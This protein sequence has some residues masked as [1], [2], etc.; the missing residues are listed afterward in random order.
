MATEKLQA[1]EAENARL[2]SLLKA[3]DRALEDENLRLRAELR[4]EN[5]RLREAKMA[6]K[7][8]L[9][10]EMV[11]GLSA[12][13]PAG[14]AK[15]MM[16]SP[17]AAAQGEEGTPEKIILE[18]EPLESEKGKAAAQKN[19]L[20]DDNKQARLA[21]IKNEFLLG[22]IICFAQVPESVA[23]AYLANVPP[24]V[25]L[26]AAWM[27]GLICSIFGG[28]PAMI[29]GATGAFAAIIST[30][31]PESQ[32]GIE[33]LFPSVMLAGLLMAGAMALRLGRFISLVPATVMIGFCNG[34]AVVI[35]LAQ[36]HPFQNTVEELNP[37][38]GLTE[39]H[40][41]MVSGP[42]LGFM[43]LIMISSM[44]TMEFLPKVPLRA[45]K[46]TPPRSPP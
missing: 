45:T 36:F 26:H 38:T 30:F 16:G 29:N 10:P 23:F 37:E 44:L 33:Y 11:S 19:P 28:R 12:Q 14:G 7:S 39:T 40:H 17:D 24:H 13:V 15:K 42:E 6:L 46:V 1:L 2:K 3:D 32:E 35:G 5:Q 8:A 43:L 9:G 34:L 41:E 22:V 27:V 18:I 31:L 20:P 4:A 25:A 21:Y